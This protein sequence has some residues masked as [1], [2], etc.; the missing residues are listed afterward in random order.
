MM[1]V[2]LLFGFLA[3]TTTIWLG[4]DHTRRPAAAHF[5]Q[6][7]A[8][9]NDA[10]SGK[11]SAPRSARITLWCSPRGHQCRGFGGSCLV[12]F[13][14]GHWQQ[15]LAERNETAQTD[16]AFEGYAEVRRNKL[17]FEFKSAPNKKIRE[18]PVDTDTKLAQSVAEALGF[19]SVTVLA[20]RYRFT[21]SMGNFGGV[22]FNIRVNSRT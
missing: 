1:R 17:L 22:V 9:E 18:I 19:N 4:Q 6:T 12:I 21:K 20:G 11:E 7:S 14:E 5:H 2:V 10:L 13:P 8:K 3:A 15:W 16:P